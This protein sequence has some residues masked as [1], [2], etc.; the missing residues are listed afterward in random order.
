MQL[1]S[2]TPIRILQGFESCISGATTDCA[3]CLE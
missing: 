1:A 2:K 3:F